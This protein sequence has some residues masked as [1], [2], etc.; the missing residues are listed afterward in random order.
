METGDGVDVLRLL[1]ISTHTVRQDGDQT[2]LKIYT[3]LL[4]R[5]NPHHPRGWRQTAGCTLRRTAAFLLRYTQFFDL[6]GVIPSDGLQSGDFGLDFFH[7]LR[8]LV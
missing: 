4:L 6:R 8:H 3:A 2:G 5:F 7:V 1:T